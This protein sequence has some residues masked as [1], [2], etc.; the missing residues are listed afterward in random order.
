MPLIET[1]FTPKYI[2]KEEKDEKDKDEENKDKDRR[3]IEEEIK[4]KTALPL[5]DEINPEIKPESSSTPNDKLEIAKSVTDQKTNVKI[6]P[7][8]IISSAGNNAVVFDP[9]NPTN[10]NVP[11]PPG[12]SRS[13]NLPS[14]VERAAS[15]IGPVQFTHSIT[16]PLPRSIMLVKPMIFNFVDKPTPLVIYEGQYSNHVRSRRYVSSVDAIKVLTEQSLEIFKVG[17]TNIFLK[18][19]PAILSPLGITTDDSVFSTKSAFD[20]MQNPNTPISQ[21]LLDIYTGE[22]TFLVFMTLNRDVIR[23][24]PALKFHQSNLQDDFYLCNEDIQVPVLPNIVQVHQQLSIPWLS[25]DIQYHLEERNSVYK[26][27]K[28][29]TKMDLIYNDKQLETFFLNIDADTASL[30]NINIKWLVN[31]RIELGLLN[32]VVASFAWAGSIIDIPISESRIPI[33][34]PDRN[35]LTASF[36][37]A[38]TRDKNIEEPILSLVLEYLH[39]SNIGIATTEYQGIPSNVLQSS[40]APVFMTEIQELISTTELH[41]IHYYLAREIPLMMDIPNFQ[42]LSYRV[43]SEISVLGIFGY[44]IL[45]LLLPQ[46]FYIY[47]RLISNELLLYFRHWYT[48]EYRLFINAYGNRCEYVNE[49]LIYNRKMVPFTM[50]EIFSTSL[51]TLFLGIPFTNCPNIT[52]IMTLFSSLGFMKADE[53]AIEAKHI[54]LHTNP[55]H[56]NPYPVKQDEFNDPFADRLRDAQLIFNDVIAHMNK[57]S[58]P[59]ATEPIKRQITHMIQRVIVISDGFS[60]HIG[61]VFDILNNFAFSV[62][63]NFHGDS[64]RHYNINY[65]VFAGTPAGK[66]RSLRRVNTGLETF[67]SSIVF[68]IMNQ[69][70]PTFTLQRSINSPNVNLIHNLVMPDPSVFADK[71][72]LLTI[73]ILKLTR[74]EAI[75]STLFSTEP[76]D[77]LIENFKANAPITNSA[78]VHQNLYSLFNR[79]VGANNVTYLKGFDSRSSE[80]GTDGRLI[81]PTIGRMNSSSNRIPYDPAI[82]TE[83][84]QGIAEFLQDDEYERLLLGLRHINRMKHIYKNVRIVMEMR[85]TENASDYPRI[86]DDIEEIAFTD[87]FFT[88][89]RQLRKTRYGIIHNNVWL[90]DPTTW[91]QYHIIITIGSIPIAPEHI[92]RLVAGITYAK[93]IVDIDIEYTTRIVNDRDQLPTL[94]VNHILAGRRGEVF[95]LVV[96]DNSLQLTDSEWSRP[97]SGD[98]W[99]YVYPLADIIKTV[100]MRGLASSSINAN[101]NAQTIF[102]LPPN[103]R[104]YDSGDLNADGELIYTDG[105]SKLNSEEICMTNAV[106]GITPP[107]SIEDGVTITCRHH[108]FPW[109][110]NTANRAIE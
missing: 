51:P 76:R 34:I 75:I 89:R 3:K 68:A 13:E 66:D 6:T 39:Q 105:S 22:L 78:R 94:D 49:R 24:P 52:T 99:Q 110:D 36:M 16:T 31:N 15:L 82:D 63:P 27:G 85:E 64:R 107:F 54:R 96:L 61:Y 79:Q 86:P 81:N 8:D 42:K 44:V 56:Y 23:Y 97:E 106:R 59:R 69:F 88:I 41:Q 74:P 102:G 95:K 109:L 11:V 17:A 14:M 9:T 77:P 90:S 28:H 29:E 91:P 33:T 30:Y 37:L 18:S 32:K 35:I 4:L 104:E 93:W 101:D 103:S 47:H 73:D 60:N 7:A 83:S 2:T 50:S 84:F 70:E 53:R 12:Y 65:G 55:S 38:A 48:A 26:Y 67:N 58:S 71:S 25:A 72:M 19:N 62:A 5:S 108:S 46:Q 21:D 100:S 1:K 43:E 10:I 92:E 80:Y 45:C 20:T 98:W 40:E 57:G 87:D